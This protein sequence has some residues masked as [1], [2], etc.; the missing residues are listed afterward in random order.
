MRALLQE[1]SYAKEGPHPFQCLGK[2][3]AVSKHLLGQLPRYREVD[4]EAHRYSG[5]IGKGE[6]DIIKRAR[7][8]DEGAVLSNKVLMVALAMGPTSDKPP[9]TFPVPVRS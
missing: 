2:Q 3:C 1:V 8:S 5:S 9:L 7:R 4:P 6:Q